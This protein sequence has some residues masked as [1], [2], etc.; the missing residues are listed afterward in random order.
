MSSWDLDRYEWV[1][2]WIEESTPC[3][4]LLGSRAGTLEVY[5]P[6]E[7]KIVHATSTYEDAMHWLTEDEFTQVR[8]RLEIE[9]AGAFA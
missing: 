8:G 1:E 3:F 9:A 6:R 2:V 5:D 7:D 4:L